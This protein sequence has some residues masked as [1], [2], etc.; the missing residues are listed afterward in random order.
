V[1]LTVADAPFVVSVA[2]RTVIVAVP[3][4]RPVTSPVE[5]TVATLLSDDRQSS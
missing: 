3:T 1:T 4:P 5:V 2:K